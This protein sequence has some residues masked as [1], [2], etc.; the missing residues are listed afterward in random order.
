MNFKKEN[1][2]L[3]KKNLT[4]VKKQKCVLI[5]RCYDKYVEY[6]NI[7]HLPV[8]L[9]FH[10]VTII[11]IRGERWCANERV[12]KTLTFKTRPQVRNLCGEVR[13]R[14]HFYRVFL[15]TWPAYMQIYRNKRKR[16]HKKRV[17]LPEDWFGTPTWPPFHFFG[18]PIWPL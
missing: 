14:N 2:K 3:G 9:W 5:F 1:L 4:R 8:K 15:I 6:Q 11:M 13:S 7:V 16:L 12:Q 18:T 17:Q 10:N